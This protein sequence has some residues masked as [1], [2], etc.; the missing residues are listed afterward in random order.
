MRLTLDT[1]LVGLG[2]LLGLYLSKLIHE[3]Q[4]EWYQRGYHE[5][6]VRTTRVRK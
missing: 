4:S 2:I 5:A 1:I 6:L 3:A